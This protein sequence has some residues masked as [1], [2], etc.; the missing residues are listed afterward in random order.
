[1]FSSTV[2]PNRGAWLEYENDANDVFYVRIDKNRKTPRDR[3]YPRSWAL[4]TDSEILDYFGEDDRIEA[5]IEKDTMQKY[6][7]RLC[8][9]FTVKLRPS[10]PPTIESAQAHIN[11]LFFDARRYDLIPGGTL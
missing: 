8:S 11:G 6:R 7:R 9:R 5:T 2:I 10:E 4:G 3:V 1:M